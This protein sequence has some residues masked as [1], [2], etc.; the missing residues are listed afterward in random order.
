MSAPGFDAGV[1]GIFAKK[2][3]APGS[4]SWSK[5]PDTALARRAGVQAACAMARPAAQPEAHAHWKL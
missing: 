5:Y 3:R 2:M 4:S 1:V